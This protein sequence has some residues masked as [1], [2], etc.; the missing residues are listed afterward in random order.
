MQ[1]TIHYFYGLIHVQADQR[2]IQMC[3]HIPGARTA[4][5]AL[6]Q[7]FELDW[8]FRRLEAWGTSSVLSLL[9]AEDKASFSQTAR[10]HCVRYV[11]L[12]RVGR[13]DA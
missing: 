11:S 3:P 4:A 6:L 7:T 13:R 2:N 1:D 9:E 10:P 5:E 12:C 8:C